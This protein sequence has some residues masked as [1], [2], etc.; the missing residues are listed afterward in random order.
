MKR[1]L[2][3]I[4]L[5]L[6]AATFGQDKQK[7]IGEIDFYGYSG[8]DLDKVHAAL[9]VREGDAFAQSDDA[10][11]DVINRVNEA[12]RQVTGRAPTDVAPVC[13]DSR[14]D[15]MI[16]VGL[17]GKSIRSVPFNPAPK[18]NLRLPPEVLSLYEQTMEA[19]SAAVR[20]G[21]A[22]EDDSKGYALSTTDST[23]RTKQL[24]TRKYAVRHE[25]LVRRVLEVARDAEQRAVAAHVLGYARR[26]DAQIA[27]LVR[28]S[29]DVDEGVRNNAIRALGV[30][31]ES[32][33]RVARRIPALGFIEMLS[34]GSWT[35]RNKAGA[36]L[37]ALSRGR[38]PKLLGQLRSQAQESLIEMARWR[39][40]GHAYP[41]RILLGR[42]AGI[43]ETRLQQL[44]QAGQVDEIINALRGAR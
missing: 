15:Y 18:G 1:Y 36:L 3:L 2:L 9:P 34:S 33:P 28:A 4:V 11:F 19:W 8:L 12:V 17:P 30:L 25:R 20:R 13:C 14:G 22:G 44:A 32:D 37:E 27:A 21:A 10:L 39:S 42:I 23:L 6:A 43:E 16:Y 26:S 24:A 5:T 35:D 41:S 7:R 40:A 31:A 38:D 29:R